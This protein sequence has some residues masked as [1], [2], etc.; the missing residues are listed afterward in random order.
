MSNLNEQNLPTEQKSRFSVAITTEKY[1]TLINNTLGDPEHAKRFIASIT[2]AVAVNPALQECTAP[3][4]VSGA[5]LGESL[6][7]SPSPQLGQ[8]YLVPFKQKEK[9]DRNGN[10]I[11]RE[12]TNATFILGYKGLVQ[13]AVRSGQIKKLNVTPIKQGELKN[14]D[15]LNEVIECELISDFDERDARPTIGYYAFFEL[16]NGYRKCMYWSK[17][18]MLHHADRYSKAFSAESYEKIQHGEI[19]DKDM[20]KYSSFWYTQFDDMACKT[21][22]R[23]LLSK[24]GAPMSIDIIDAVS[25]DGEAINI[26]NGNFVSIPEEDEPLPTIPEPEYNEAEIQEDNTIDLSSL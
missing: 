23:Q 17:K 20:W 21:M 25:K 1:K 15:P 8:Y 13:L 16:I 2:S 10:I 6:K 14:Y 24:G 19:S 12:C 26:Q 18:Q 11:Q 4:I 5:L 3:T 22:L 9:R 7:L